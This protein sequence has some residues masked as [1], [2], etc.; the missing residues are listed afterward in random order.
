MRFVVAFETAILRL[1]PRQSF[2]AKPFM[3]LMAFG[4]VQAFLFMGLMAIQA[5]PLIMGRCTGGV[6]LEAVGRRRQVTYFPVA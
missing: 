1:I 4:A 6:A 3:N 2:P 5:K